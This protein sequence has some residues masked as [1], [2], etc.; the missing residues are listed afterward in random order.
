[1]GE[2]STGEVLPKSIQRAIAIRD[3]DVGL[4]NFFQ[5]QLKWLAGIEWVVD[6]QHP[7]QSHWAGFLVNFIIMKVSPVNPS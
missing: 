4:G 6:V 2:R 5:N 1:M 3:V 7:A